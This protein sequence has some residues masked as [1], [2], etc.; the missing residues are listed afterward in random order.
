MRHQRERYAA[1]AEAFRLHGPSLHPSGRAEKPERPATAP[2]PLGSLPGSRTGHTSNPLG[3]INPG[4]GG[5]NS[6]TR[7]GEEITARG[8]EA[9]ATLRAMSAR[10]ASQTYRWVPCQNK[11][12]EGNRPD[13]ATRYPAPPATAATMCVLSLSPPHTLPPKQIPVQPRRT[14]YKDFHTTSRMAFNEAYF[15]QRG[16]RTQLRG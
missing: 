9:Q 3:G 2:P 10:A 6:S 14:T 11:K 7:L 5:L 16:L 15:T 13:C 12:E 1:A 8:A 4:F